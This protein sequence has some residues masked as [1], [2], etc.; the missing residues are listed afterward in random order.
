MEYGMWWQAPVPSTSSAGSTG[1]QRAQI[2]GG[3]VS[4]AKIPPCRLCCTNK[5][6]A[7]GHERRS[8]V[9]S[10]FHLHFSAGSLETPLMNVK[11]DAEILGFAQPIIAVAD[12]DV[13][14]S[15]NGSGWAAGPGI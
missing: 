10:I 7:F 13:V 4:N 2:S 14:F 6:G 3:D 5:E 1:P 11:R 9:I 12:S 8:I 15:A